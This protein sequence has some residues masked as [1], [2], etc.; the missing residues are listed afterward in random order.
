MNQQHSMLGT[1]SLKGSI[2]AGFVLLLVMI[3]VGGM[4]AEAPERVDEGTQELYLTIPIVG[5]VVSLG[6]GIGGLAKK[7]K[8]KLP[9]ILGTAL[10]VA[11][12]LLAIY[13][14]FADVVTKAT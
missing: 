6:L 5:L 1:A 13:F 2:A 9:A 10:S 8:N 7:E 12:L 4:Q 3:V 11:A 14:I